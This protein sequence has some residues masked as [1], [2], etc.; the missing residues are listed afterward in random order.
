MKALLRAIEKPYRWAALYSVLLSLLFAFALLDT[1]A[2]PKSYGQVETPPLQGADGSE[3][4]LGGANEPVIT[5]TSYDDGNIRITVA[6]TRAYDTTVHIA[7]VSLSDAKYLKAAFAGN[8][9]GRN[10][11]ETTSEMAEEHNAILAVNGDYYGF[12]DSGTVLRNGTLY[13]TGS[14]QRSLVMFGN[15]DMQAI[16]EDSLTAE[17]F[18][19]LW[20]AWTFGPVLVDGGEV[21]VDEQSEVTGRSSASNPRTAIG[22]VGPLEYVFVVSEGRISGEAGLSLEE[23]ARVMADEGCQV[24]YNLD[25]GGSTTMVFMGNVVNQ[26][27]T[28][29]KNRGERAVSDIVYIG[30]E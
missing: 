25:G 19:S 11:T 2:I 26:P 7:H 15:G 14:G 24:A 29:G 21:G 12:S 17:M 20:Q 16:S 6:T 13:R 1:F 30:Y 5:D 10:I 23:L 28:S 18:S 4:S 8:T 3:N 27:A 22:Q 9:Y